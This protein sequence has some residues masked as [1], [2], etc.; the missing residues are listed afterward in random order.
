MD[1]TGGLTV[2]RGAALYVGGEFT[3]A[4]TRSGGGIAA[5]RIARWNGQSWSALGSGLDGQAD[6]LAVFDD[7]AGPA[8]YAAGAFNNAGGQPAHRIAR[9]RHNAWSAVG[10]GLDGDASAL[11][12]FGLPGS[13]PM[14]I[15]GG[16]FTTAGGLP[17]P[18]IAAWGP[19]WSPNCDHST[20]PPVLTISDF[21]CFLNRFAAADP[22]ANCD[23]S[24]T[25]PVLNVQDFSCFLNRFAS[26]DTYANCDAST[27]PP[28][29]NI[30][31]FS[32]FL[33]R[34]AAGCP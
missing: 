6:A 25:A 26:G 34:F 11:T 21:S 23:G 15:V 33:N 7:G 12:V 16:A 28:A 27:N 5:S 32:C 24:T 19:R 13:Q 17:A 14:L 18:H 4:D 30:L 2:T 22:Y 29:L 9:W 20:T 3:R 8:L 31:D 10:Q 1:D